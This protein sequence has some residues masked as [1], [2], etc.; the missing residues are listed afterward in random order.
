MEKKS[1]GPTLLVVTILG[2]IGILIAPLALDSFASSSDDGEGADVEEKVA[3]E[4]VEKKIGFQEEYGLM[5]PMLRRQM[6]ATNIH[7]ITT[8]GK[9]TKRLKDWSVKTPEWFDKIDSYI[10]CQDGMGCKKY[11][12]FKQF[13]IDLLQPKDL[14]C[15]QS[16]TEAECEVLRIKNVVLIYSICAIGHGQILLLHH[17]ESMEDWGDLDSSDWSKINWEKNLKVVHRWMNVPVIGGE[18]VTRIVMKFANN[19]G[20]AVDNIGSSYYSGSKMGTPWAEAK[21]RGKKILT[22]LLGGKTNPYKDKTTYGRAIKRCYKGKTGYVLAGLKERDENDETDGSSMLGIPNVT[23]Y[24]HSDILA[25]RGCIFQRETG[26]ENASFKG[27]DG[28][29]RQEKA[30]ISR[31]IEIDLISP[32]EVDAKFINAPQ[33]QQSPQPNSGSATEPKPKK[34]ETPKPTPAKAE[35]N[36]ICK[37]GKICITTNGKEMCITPIVP[38]E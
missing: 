16:M 19:D 27:R 18:Y 3:K 30:W 21:R 26:G 32:E 31:G 37:N 4:K 12:E 22:G 2:V 6:G 28:A 9:N 17:G 5:S 33:P 38:C 11:S 25:L 29:V 35:S 14:V 36:S 15:N 24:Q 8:N 13:S 23:P 10:V 1:V 34:E 20:P 7:A